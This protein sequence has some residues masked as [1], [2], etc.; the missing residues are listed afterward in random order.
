MGRIVTIDCQYIFPKFAAAYLLIDDGKAAFID[1]NTAHSVPLLL[2]ALKE[3][4]LKPEQVEYVIITHVHLD[5]A[6]GTSQL[7]A[8]CPNATLLTH[9]R[10]AR[11]MIDPS[12]LVASARIVYGN[13]TFDKLYGRIEPID[14]KRVR[15]MQD[16][17][18]LA[19]GSSKLHFFHTRGHANHH[20]CI[21]DQASNS[22]FTGDSFGLAYPALQTHGLFIFPTT[23][24]TDFDPKEAKLSVQRIVDTGALNAYPTHFGVVED[25]PGASKQLLAELDFSEELLNR[26]QQRVGTVEE[27]T[28]YCK[29][30]IYPHFNYL[31][32]RHGI[33][34]APETWK[35]LKLDL[36]INAAGIAYVA[37]KRREETK[38]SKGESS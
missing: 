30:E 20:M 34:T 24:P 25:L 16:G 31:L 9:P 12:K 13:E 37:H 15:V 3:Q 17:E 36:D 7:M 32:E 27:L 28:E 14:E 33:S 38:K 11:H 18:D 8:A 2:Q 23:S 10:A 19:L 21:V 1:N 5:H 26:A 4:G 29:S 22:V 35:L 6:G